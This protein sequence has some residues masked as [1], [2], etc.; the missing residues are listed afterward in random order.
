MDMMNVEVSSRLIHINIEITINM[1]TVA[2]DIIKDPRVESAMLKTDRASYCP[3]DQPY[4]DRPFP[5]GYGATISAP[6]MHA[7]ALEAL[8]DKL[9]EGAKVLDVGSGSGYLTACFAHMVGPT[10]RVY[11][12]EHIGEL[13]ERSIENIRN[14]NSDLLDSGTIQILSKFC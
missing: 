10:G 4:L 6:H 5:I 2:N 8:N 1:Y 7:H 14:D 12:V 13:V 9:E 3:G 11:G